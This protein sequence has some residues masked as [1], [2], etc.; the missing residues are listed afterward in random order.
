MLRSIAAQQMWSWDP[1]WS[2]R[3]V[4]VH[5]YSRPIDSCVVFDLEG[6]RCFRRE[7]QYDNE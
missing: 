7:L 3:A 4:S 5:V 2:E 6:Q 1:E